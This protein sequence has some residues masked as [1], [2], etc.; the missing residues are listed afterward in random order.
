M[1]GFLMFLEKNKD[2]IFG[3]FGVAVLGA[4]GWAFKKIFERISKRI[5]Q[6]QIVCK[7]KNNYKVFSG[8][9]FTLRKIE[10]NAN[11]EAD[12]FDVNILYN[13]KKQTAKNLEVFLNKYC[14]NRKPILLFGNGGDGKTYSL[15]KFWKRH[16]KNTIYIRL[17]ALGE[18]ENAIMS[19]I[20]NEIFE[21]V[22]TIYEKFK[23]NYSTLKKRKPLFLLLD[24][25]NE[26]ADSNLQNQIIKEIKHINARFNFQIVITSRYVDILNINMPEFSRA[27]MNGLTRGQIS[28]CL[29]NFYKKR[30]K[31]IDINV[32]LNDKG[33]M[34]LFKSPLMLSLFMQT[35][36]FYDPLIRDDKRTDLY[37]SLKFVG[38]IY[39]ESTIIWN[40]I[41]SE[42]RKTDDTNKNETVFSFIVAN[43]ISPFIAY[44]M[45]KKKEK[46]YT[47]SREEL[48]NL[49][50][51]GSEYCKNIIDNELSIEFD[52]LKNERIFE[53][54]KLNKEFLL[55]F[56]LKCSNPLLVANA[57]VTLGTD[58]TYGFFHQQ[59]RDCL[60]AI[61]LINELKFAKKDN[62]I[63]AVW[64]EDFSSNLYMVR[65]IAFLENRNEPKRENVN[66]IFEKLRLI[67][68]KT[69]IPTETY[70]A[71]LKNVLLVYKYAFESKFWEIDFSN[72]DLRN[73]SLDEFNFQPP[74]SESQ[75]LNENSF[76]RAIFGVK[77]FALKGHI[78]NVGSL[79]TN[80]DNLL[81]A[82]EYSVRLW[83]IGT[84]KCTDILYLT[85]TPFAYSISACFLPNDE[86]VIAYSNGNKISEITL[87]VSSFDYE[88]NKPVRNISYSPNGK[89]I[90]AVMEDGN[91]TI[92]ERNNPLSI[93]SSNFDSAVYIKS[94][95]LDDLIAVGFNSEIK[96]IDFKQEK[97][98]EFHI[99]NGNDSC[100]ITALSF[101][102]LDE[103]MIA[104]A[105]STEKSMFIDII[106]LDEKQDKK[107]LSNIHNKTIT[108]L[109]FSP[110]GES[111]G[112]CSLDCTS[113]VINISNPS[114]VV[115]LGTG[116]P[117]TSISFKKKR[118]V[119]N[120]KELFTGDKSG[121]ISLNYFG[122]ERTYISND[123]NGKNSIVFDISINPKNPKY[124]LV[125]YDDGNI[126]KWNIDNEQLIYTY[127]RKHTESVNCVAYSPDGSYFASGS[128]TIFLWNA[129]DNTFIKPF[130]GHNGSICDL[131]F[132]KTGNLLISCSTDCTIRVWDIEKDKVCKILKGHENYV[133]RI[134]YFEDEKISRLVSCSADGYIFIWDFNEIISKKDSDVIPQKIKAHENRIRSI[135][136]AKFNERATFLSNS[137]DGTIKEWYIEDGEPTG[138]CVSIEE[139]K[140]SSEAID[141][142]FDSNTIL[143]DC[144]TGNW[145]PHQKAHLD[146]CE[147]PL[148]A[149]TILCTYSD[150]NGKLTYEG[151]FD[152]HTGSIYCALY[153][154]N[155][156]Q[157]LSGSL[158]GSI[159]VYDLLKN[160]V[161]HKMLPDSTLD[162]KLK[163]YN[164]DS[165]I[166]SP[167]YIKY[168]YAGIRKQIDYKKYEE[169]AKAL[170][171]GIVLN[172]FDFIESEADIEPLVDVLI[173]NTAGLFSVENKI[174]QERHLFLSN[175]LYLYLVKDVPA[176]EQNMFMLAELIM[177]GIGF[178]NNQD[179]KTD[180]DRLFGMLE[181]KDESHIALKHYK[182]I[183]EIRNEDV[184]VSCYLR[185][186]PVM[187]TNEAGL[188]PLKG[189]TINRFVESF[190]SNTNRQDGVC[191]EETLLPV[192]R[193]LVFAMICAINKKFNREDDNDRF[194]DNCNN[195][196]EAIK[197][198]SENDITNNTD[199]LKT[200]SALDKETK[201]KLINSVSSRL[202]FFRG[203]G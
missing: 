106:Y 71:I 88:G 57:V 13:D 189:D 153:I 78:G 170:N 109:K 60:A 192:E 171:R 117:S 136:L 52:N 81:S 178:E 175:I 116:L 190:I 162:K 9:D 39:S 56:M 55:N 174:N 8:Q 201:M 177:A 184:F 11:N 70:N 92:W 24:G 110:D 195:F 194:T 16:T 176:D 12:M 75:N 38:P 19:Y 104:V 64:V 5:P 96:V 199:L 97:I 188:F 154:N 133:S 86:R 61:Y 156:T 90:A 125:A 147:L 134:L 166:F 148:A 130:E 169:F 44:E 160:E 26:I 128:K 123:Y 127:P 6:R 93:Y 42:V 182:K 99:G 155:Y 30:N 124:C 114:D 54:E 94:N 18:Q 146:Q 143:F 121:N 3:G 108:D 67:D 84:V 122:I 14:T 69:S 35:S 20:E 25:F 144:D 63:P 168:Q 58:T 100:E 87:G 150:N 151:T 40:Y 180:L 62:S 138:R 196:L 33:I 161:V 163:G 46:A 113:K 152:Y 101:N 129:F 173:E 158:D 140:G 105:Y 191:V 157:I 95:C 111:L 59:L 37:N 36:P 43:F 89:F 181:E 149:E 142:D 77:T 74:E 48:K 4:V 85:E 167:E 41:Q 186:F 47:L 126:R 65:H 80:G 15:Y 53:I 197:E 137:D 66:Y 198:S 193:D 118:E 165:I 32:V 17:Y 73:V 119:E 132:N 202:D 50:D 22:H 1:D 2:L 172:L 135:C 76:S 83:S 200:F 102:A 68:G 115:E 98:S 10:L 79:D 49:L 203:C 31:S 183:K 51:K 34:E 145:R 139:G 159:V 45:Q 28:D 185:L 103:N 120:Y 21:S 72:I 179:Y 7:I 27:E 107:T 112:S 82:D 141:Y 29:T 187:A 91:V 131:T 23:H 164:K